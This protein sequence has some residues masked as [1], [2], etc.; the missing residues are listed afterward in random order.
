MLASAVAGS[1]RS[2]RPR[3]GDGRRRTNAFDV[4]TRRDA[5]SRRSGA[6]ARR[7]SRLTPKRQRGEVQ[8]LVA[9]IT[10]S[11]MPTSCAFDR[12]EGVS[13]QRTLAVR[14]AARTEDDDRSGAGA[15]GTG[16]ALGFDRAI[17]GAVTACFTGGR[18]RRRTAVNRSLPRRCPTRKR[19]PRSLRAKAAPAWRYAGFAHGLRF[20]P[21]PCGVPKL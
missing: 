19:L 10:S 21:A 7:G 1:T 8:T 18:A 5:R 13:S 12:R 14:R 4:S 9:R 3:P 15:T 20:A 17:G 2:G 6:L 16:R 11:T